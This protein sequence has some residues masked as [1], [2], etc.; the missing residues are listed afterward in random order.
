MTVFYHTLLLPSVLLL[1][2][3]FAAF[4]LVP[5][6]ILS[7]RMT[8]S[9]SSCLYSSTKGTHLLTLDPSTLSKEG[10]SR[11]QLAKDKDYASAILKAWAD[12]VNNRESL[13]V[14]VAVE[15][16]FLLRS[17]TKVMMMMMMMMDRQPSMDTSTDHL[18][19]PPPLLKTP[20]QG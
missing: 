19:R 5:S 12:E 9:S 16:Q 1:P 11:P 20:C 8:S 2:A 14:K 7:R 13:R 10:E 18:Y 15:D 3:S 4:S 17:Y 6:F